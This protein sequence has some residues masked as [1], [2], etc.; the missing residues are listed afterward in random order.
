MGDVETLY[1]LLN[2]QPNPAILVNLTSEGD[3]TLLMHTI[4]GAG[5]L[6][7]RVMGLNV[8]RKMVTNESAL[9]YAHENF[10]INCSLEPGLCCHPP[11]PPPDQKQG[12]VPPYAPPP[13][14]TKSRVGCHRMS[15]PQTKSMHA[16]WGATVCPPPPPPG[17]YA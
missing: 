1:L 6:A 11:P 7:C 9:H 4:I 8:T 13:P 3:V 12:G 5:N 10:Q 2:Q 15:P 14:Q 16:G 17:C